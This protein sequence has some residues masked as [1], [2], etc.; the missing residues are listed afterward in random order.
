VKGRACERERDR[1]RNRHR[2]RSLS[3]LA[4]SVVLLS[5][6]SLAHSQNATVNVT[7]TPDGQSLAGNLGIT[8]S[9]LNGKVQSEIQTY[10]QTTHIA[11]IMQA[12]VDTAAFSNRDLGVDYAPRNGEIVI[13]A[14]AAGAIDNS[15]TLPTKDSAYTNAIV[16]GGVMAGANLGRWGLPRWSVFANGFYLAQQIEALEGHLTTLGAHVEYQILLPTHPAGAQ[17]LGLF[18]VTGVEYAHTDLFA[19]API[20]HKFTVDGTPPNSINLTLKSTGTLQLVADTVTVPVELT[21]GVRLASVLAVYAG[22]GV[23][24]TGGGATLTAGLSGN[25]TVT[26]TGDDVGSVT[27]TDSATQGPTT[28]TAHALAGLQ[29]DVPHFQ[30]YLQGTLSPDITA[31]NFGLRVAF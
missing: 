29:L 1:G 21:T 23:D 18:A 12:F 28:V 26:S 11:T 5:S 24:F 6:P 27:I 25:M 22:G 7:L 3:L 17:W 13:G 8:S 9:A 10:Y 4:F 19:D 20:V 30:I 2:E 31:A 15:I 14:V 16:N